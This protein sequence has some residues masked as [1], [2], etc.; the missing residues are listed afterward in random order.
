MNQDVNGHRKLF[1]KEVSKV[2]GGK[3]ENYSR[4]K[5]GNGGLALEEVEVCRNWK[6]Y[7]EDLCNVDT[8]KQV[9][10]HICGFDGAQ[11]DNYFGEEPISKKELE[12]SWK[13]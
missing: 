9:A 5:D 10:A 6:E 3:L 7:F 8:Q 1:W 4:I 11:R 12:V 2:I 13:T